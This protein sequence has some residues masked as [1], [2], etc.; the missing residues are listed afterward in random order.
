MR[1]DG[2]RGDGHRLDE[3]VRVALHDDPV[4]EGAGLG[5]V[6]VA[7]QVVRTVGLGRRGLPFAAGGEG[8]AAAPDQA[9]VGDLAD[10]PG[11][12]ECEGPPQRGVPAVCPVVVERG[13]VDHTDTAQQHEG[14]IARPGHREGRGRLLGR[15]AGGA[16]RLR[17]PR[18]GGGRRHGRTHR[19]ARPDREDR[20]S[21]LAQPQAGAALDADAAAGPEAGLD[22]GAQL[23]RARRRAREVR[24]HVQH[25]RGARLHR[26]HRVEGRDP[27]RLRRRHGQPAAQ[28]VER[29]LADPAD[30]VVDGVQ[31]RQQ[32]VAAFARLPAAA[33]PPEVGGR[34][35][36]AR[37]ALPRGLRRTEQPVDRRPL[38]V[39]RLAVTE[40]QIHHIT[41]LESRPAASRSGWPTP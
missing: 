31:P 7:H 28:V 8:G 32:Q 39:R 4:L 35:L 17:R 16:R 24:T 38:L 40:V 5:L 10:D 14:G 15:R 22:P 36:I 1:P 2:V 20:R 41:S 11:R 23:R 9:R 12:P 13:G 33:R 37:G 6:G 30:P 3:G 21:A 18:D 26:E 19:I 29:A 34:H 25:G 27:V